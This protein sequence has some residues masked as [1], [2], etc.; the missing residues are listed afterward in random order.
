MHRILTLLTPIT[1]AAALAATTAAAE[2]SIQLLAD[3]CAACHGTDGDSPGSIDE[4]DDIKRAEFVED[5]IEFKTG[6]GKG[7]IMAPIARGISD[8]QIEALADHFEALSSK[9]N[10]P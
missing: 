8:A 10:K 2:P 4:L 6:K 9:G 1:L 5:M 3:S 7:R